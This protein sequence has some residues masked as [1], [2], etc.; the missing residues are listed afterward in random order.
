MTSLKKLD[1]K[2]YGLFPTVYSMSAPCC[3]HDYFASVNPDYIKED[4]KEYPNWVRKQQDK[5][6]DLIVRLGR[7][8]R[9]VRVEVVPADSLKGVYYSFRYRLNSEMAVIIGKKV[10]KGEDLDL[11]KIENYVKSL[12]EEK[13]KV[14]H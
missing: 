14:K 9:Y 10:F 12:I 6:V 11:N 7:Y 3:T 5:M 1:I 4:M 2:I 8:G 13:I